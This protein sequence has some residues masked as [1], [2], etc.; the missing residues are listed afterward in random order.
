MTES[1][2]SDGRLLVGRYRFDRLLGHGGMGW[3][4]AAHDETLGRDVAVKEVVPPPDLTP[5]QGEAIR[6]R[7]LREARA[8]A[9]IAHPSA[10]TVYDVVEEGGRPYIVMQLLPSR[11]LADVLTDEGPLPPWRV[12]RIGVDLVEALDTAHRAGVL[13]RDVKPANVMLMESGRAV[14]TDFGIATVEGD[15]TVTTTGMLVGS[16]AYMAPERARGERP[17]PAADLWSLGATLFAAVEAQPPFRRDGQLPT[18]NAVLTEEPPPAEHAG[19]LRPVIGALLTRDPGARPT[20]AQT[21]D[22]LLRAAAEAEAEAEATDVLDADVTGAALTDANVSGADVADADAAATEVVH[23]DRAPTRVV[24]A[25]PDAQGV[26]DADGEAPGMVDAESEAPGMVDAEARDRE[27]DPSEVRPAAIAVVDEH[28]FQAAPAIP[29]PMP[30]TRTTPPPTG[31]PT[32]P[33]PGSHPRLSR[34]RGA[35]ALAA[36]LVLVLALGVFALMRLLGGGTSGSAAAG[37]SSSSESPQSSATAGASASTS[38]TPTD[39]GKGSTSSGGSSGSGTSSGTATRGSSSGSGN[40][41]GAASAVP[42]GF[43]RHTDPTGFSLVVP[44][45]WTVTRKGSDVTFHQPGGRA[46][47]LVPQ[48]RQPRA[49]S[50]VDWQEQERA[51]SPG[52]PGYQRIRLE[53]VAFHAGWDVADWEFRWTPSGGTLHVIDRNLRISDRRAYALYWSVP[54]QNWNRMLNTFNVIAR[55]FRPAP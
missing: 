14:L 18:L 1:L 34:G 17:T 51:A 41:Q 48:T 47:L 32:T 38:P 7:T 39:D 35:A 20:A 21:R 6:R 23:T 46:F 25:E 53:R 42:A 45:G 13:H 37:S 49:D 29:S 4:W 52:F 55:S 11:T 33:P 19:P 26:V 9:R 40:G 2:A 5:E 22:L 16:P 8:A 43:R 10:V 30:A 12:A 24:E 3:V 44:S 50:L 54:E 28:P 36:A 31:P 27:V 15:P